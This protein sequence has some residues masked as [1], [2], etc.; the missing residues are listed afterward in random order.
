[1]GWGEEGPPACGRGAEEAERTGSVVGP[2]QAEQVE[3]PL[4]DELGLWHPGLWHLLVS[5][6][7]DEAGAGGAGAVGAGA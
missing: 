7:Q 2:T 1:M 4:G 6:V 5:E 3:E